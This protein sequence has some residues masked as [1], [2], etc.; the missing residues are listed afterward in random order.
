MVL[1]ILPPRR[2]LSYVDPLPM[3]DGVWERNGRLCLFWGAPLAQTSY[4][5]A[6]DSPTDSL[7]HNAR[8]WRRRT[9]NFRPTSRRQVAVGFALALLIIFLIAGFI[10]LR[11][12]AEAA[13]WVGTVAAVVALFIT[14]MGFLTV[15]QPNSGGL[16]NPA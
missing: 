13:T 11:G 14:I 15:R 6:L 12:Q 2:Q 10:A 9:P 5:F 7:A 8:R 1:M 4:A 16:S 3:C